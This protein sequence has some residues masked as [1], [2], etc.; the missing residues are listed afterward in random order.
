VN[1]G[2]PAVLSESDRP[3]TGLDFDPAG[4][5]LAS[6]SFMIYD[7]GDGELDGHL[8]LRPT[9]TGLMRLAEGRVWRN[10]SCVEW[11]EYVGPEV[12]YRRTFDSL[13]FPDD[14]SLCN[15]VD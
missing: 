13:P 8:W 9:T 14:L 4:Y 15:D 2:P 12:P 11:M 6:S 1:G 3:V 10:L 5:W 7:G